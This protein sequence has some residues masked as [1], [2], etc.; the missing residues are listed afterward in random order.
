MNRN[1][2]ATARPLLWGTSIA[3]LASFAGAFALSACGGSDSPDS[4]A[5]SVGAGGITAIVIDSKVSPAFSGATFGSAGQYEILV[6][7]AYGEVDPNDKRNSIVT[8][9][10][11]APRNARGFVEYMSTFQIVKPIDMTK[12]SGLMWHD[13]PNRGGRITIS[14]AERQQGDVGLSSGWQ[15]DNSGATAVGTA[16]KDYAVVPI[17]KNDDGTPITGTVLGRI[18]NAVGT[19][20]QGFIP[21]SNPLPYKPVS[22]DTTLSTLTQYDSE[23]ID[24]TAGPAHVI[25]STDWAWGKCDAT[26]PF[27]GTPDG[28]QVCLKNGFTANKMYQAV[29]TAQ[30]PYVLGL[31][32]AAYRDLASFLKYGGNSASSPPNPLGTPAKYIIGRGSSQSGRFLR[33]FLMLGFNQ[34]MS[35][36]QVQDG[37]WPIIAG[38]NIWLNMRWAVPDA[39]LKTFDLAMEGPQ[40]WAPYQDTVRGL[41]SQSLLDRCNATNTCPKIVEHNGAA[42]VWGLKLTLA[43]VGTDG[44]ADLPLPSNVRRY[45]IA[46]TP[47]GGGN[48]AI[49]EN[50]G[51]PGT[52]PSPGWGTATYPNNPLPHT[53]T[54][55]AIEGRFRQWVMNGIAPPDSV[56]PHLSDG[57]AAAATK[58]ALGFPSIPG[59]PTAAPTG[60]ISNVL[61]YDLGSNFNYQNGSGV[62]TV[63]P[64]VIKQVIPA[65]APTVDA[66]GNERGGV[67]A[68]LHDAPLGTYMGWNITNG[69]FH[70]G[71]ECSYG[72]G[73]IP[74][75][76]TKAQRLASGDP[77]PSLEERYV[78]HAGYVA[79]VQA[80]GANAVSKGFL[81][82][83]DADALTARAQAS[84]VLN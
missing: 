38:G 64:P 70:D 50:P 84:D 80:A 83:P 74:F 23:T 48:G 25:P 13:V 20:S 11:K 10:D 77:R 59:V 62:P 56:W 29:F 49:T 66:D 12:A 51:A 61:D 53:E 22:L 31:G 72:G 60:L 35:G 9:I 40:W 36:R 81:L 4:S 79:A 15:G 32:F 1:V 5:S 26:H 33:S 7:R 43:W 42:E 73:M 34:D 6:G 21:Q 82:Q 58:G 46:G 30:D 17:A 57:T 18:F 41:P 67:P 19:S 63:W 14:V 65:V 55:N 68:V 54:V 45:Y 37:T 44:K 52:C 75:A 69:G 8:D 76:I 28:T 16:G 3:C 47:H 27:P 2:R 39:G 78:N 24:G 71:Q